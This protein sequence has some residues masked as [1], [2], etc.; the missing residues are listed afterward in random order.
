M[1]HAFGKTFQRLTAR[2][3]VFLAVAAAAETETTSALL[4]SRDHRV[5]LGGGGGRQEHTYTHF[6]SFFRR[7]SPSLPPLFPLDPHN[8]DACDHITISRGG[9]QLC[10]SLPQSTRNRRRSLTNERLASRNASQGLLPRSTSNRSRRAPVVG[11]LSYLR[12]L[13]PAPVL[14]FRP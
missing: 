3:L 6:P 8:D 4:R 10:L 12:R 7:R 5:I 2:E 13:F 11:E 14:T 1:K 9:D